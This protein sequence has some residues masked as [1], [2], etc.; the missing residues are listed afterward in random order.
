MARKITH[1][2]TLQGELVAQTPIHIGGADIADTIDMPLAVNGMGEY[3]L[4]GTS[5]A[6]AI[7]AWEHEEEPDEKDKTEKKQEEKVS[8]KKESWGFADKDRGHASFFIVDDA[9][10]LNAPV[11]ELWHGVGIDRQTG[12]AFEGVKFDRQVLPKGTRFNFRIQREVPLT[13]KRDTVRLQMQQLK[14]ALELAEIPFGGSSTRGFG[15]LKLEKAKASEVEWESRE[16]ILEWLNNGEADDTTRQ[17]EDALL[18]ISNEKPISPLTIEI[19]WQ[20]TGPL[21]SKA[22]QDGIT[23]DMLP[24]IS[25]IEDDL[26]AMT[27]PGSAIKGTL[28]Q[29]AERIVRTVLNLDVTGKQHFDQTDV[30]LVNELFGSARGKDEMVDGKLQPTGG[31]KG[32][33]AV[34]TCYSELSLSREEWAQLDR[35]DRKWTG[36]LYKADHVAID[37]WTGA[38]S[39]GALFNTVEPDRTVEWAPIRLRYDQKRGKDNKAALALL[40]LVLQDLKQGH[41]PLGFGVNRGYGSLQVNKVEIQGL[42]SFGFDSVQDNI[43]LENDWSTNSLYVELKQAWTNWLDQQP[44]KEAA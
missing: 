29:Q 30:L 18:N 22:A 43:V 8:K 42:N 5:I 1:T 36:K 26:F 2:L 15:R 39:D 16:G 40:W 7:R 44:K 9:P 33:L 24:F 3:Y 11:A 6:G 28:R 37:R 32:L 4:P 17:W 21:M 13:Q 35:G 20:P 12:G 23:A 34:D 38:A 31:S 27:L 10:V 25:R 41:I 19:H 14:R